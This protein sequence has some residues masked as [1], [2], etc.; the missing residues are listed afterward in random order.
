MDGVLVA[1]FHF[2]LSFPG[3]RNKQRPSSTYALL[4]WLRLLVSKGVVKEFEQ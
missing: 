2:L 4:D 3:C 1:F